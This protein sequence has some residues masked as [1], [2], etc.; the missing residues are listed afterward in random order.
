MGSLPPEDSLLALQS[1][2]WVIQR[3]AGGN[4]SRTQGEINAI[5]NLEPGELDLKGE[6]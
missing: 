6:D 1:Y 5:E 4:P 2:G 3:K